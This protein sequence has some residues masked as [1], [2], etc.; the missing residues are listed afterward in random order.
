MV[1]NLVMAIVLSQG[2]ATNADWRAVA[3][4][5]ETKCVRRGFAV[6]RVDDIDRTAELKRLQPAYTAFVRTPEE[7]RFTDVIEISRFVRTLDDDPLEDTIWGIVTGPTAAD[8]L[9]VATAGRPDLSVALSTTGIDESRYADFVTFS[10]ANPPGV[11]VSRAADGT[12]VSEQTSG[13]LSERFAAEWDRLDPGVIVTSSHASERNLEMPFSRGNVVVKDGA[14]WTCPNAQLID[15]RTGQ[16]SS[17][18]VT[19]A[20]RLA[21]PK[22]AKVWFAPG[23]CLIGNNLDNSSMVMTA[24]GYGRCDQFFGY[25]V[26]TWFGAVGWGTWGK[27]QAGGVTMAQARH[28]AVNEA[29]DR[30]MTMCPTADEFMPSCPS[31]RAYERTFFLGIRRFFGEREPDRD[32]MGL[33]WDRDA[34]VVWGDPTLPTEL[35]PKQAAKADG[36]QR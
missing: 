27:W 23:N 36:S 9:R 26:T 14:F 34:T 10:D 29:I 5:L 6:T 4:A 35:P 1:T 16:S 2:V 31:A 22:R 12:R 21:K 30:L 17:N 19:A 3:D 20:R 28:L 18:R 8:A 11:V 32:V 24:L 33:L 13:D 7:S 25:M 15:Y